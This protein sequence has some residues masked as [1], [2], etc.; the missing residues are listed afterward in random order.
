MQ[1]TA[2]T[3]PIK[4]K[5]TPKKAS[6]K[7]LNEVF[8]YDKTKLIYLV[9]FNIFLTC[10]ILKAFFC[11]LSIGYTCCNTIVI[12][13]AIVAILAIMALLGSLYVTIFPQR[14]ALLTDTGITIDHNE[15]LKWDE[16]KEATE[17]V[18]TYIYKQNAIALHTKDGVSHNLRFMQK[19]CKNNVFTPFSIPLYAMRK[20]D[21][22]KIRKLIKQKC[23]YKNMK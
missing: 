22:E 6:K 15:E 3:K 12:M 20:K 5:T 2:K 4:G 14:L 10:F 7:A 1:K 8:F 17:F 11:L 18:T 23:K 19:M 9:L 21:A 13:L 16:I